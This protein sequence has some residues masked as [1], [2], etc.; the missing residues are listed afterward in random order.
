VRKPFRGVLQECLGISG[1]HGACR[2]T[3]AT[4]LFKPA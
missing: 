1:I 4:P 3:L 2:F